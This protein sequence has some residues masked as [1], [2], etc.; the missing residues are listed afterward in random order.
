MVNLV[1]GR[2]RYSFLLPPF[3]LGVCLAVAAKVSVGLLLYGG[4]GFLRA[5]SVILATLAAAL[6]FGLWAGR[7]VGP[8]SSMEAVRLRWLLTLVAFTGAV[9]FAG[10]WEYFGAFGVQPWSQALGLA[11]LAGLPL[12]FGGALL[13]VMTREDSV[14]HPKADVSRLS[15]GVAVI[16]GVGA[17]FLATGFVLFPR[18]SAPH[19]LLVCVVFL[20]LG[21]LIHGWILDQIPQVRVV[22]RRESHRGEVRVEHWVRGRPRR[23]LRAL[24]VNGEVRGLESEGGDPELPGERAV[25]TFLN[26]L[27][28]PES[29]LFVGGGGLT[30]P[31]LVKAEDPSC[32]VTVL[33]ED[34][35]LTEL[36][37]EHFLVS[38]ADA[39]DV[40]QGPVGWGRVGPD[41][42]S[43]VVVLAASALDDSVPTLVALRHILP[44]VDDCLR[45]G[46]VAVAVGLPRGA[47]SELGPTHPQLRPILDQG[48]GR[49]PFRRLYAHDD[50]VMIVFA[51]RTLELP[52]EFEGFLLAQPELVPVPPESEPLGAGSVPRAGGEGPGG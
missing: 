30:L 37:L 6:A 5:L 8:E 26:Q 32:R 12:F 47:G 13:G 25:R 21:A 7:S 40:Q 43:A 14:L 36:A 9:V 3:I 50:E 38:E 49:F 52:E 29:I 51:H 4:V 23:V 11:L 45:P 48:S 19:L 16:L 27:G 1:D 42:G 22:G 20:S 41:E 46:G 24:L 35:L 10:T 15:P 17:G 28:K 34:P 18:F 39:I 2:W 33:E 31:R 44:W